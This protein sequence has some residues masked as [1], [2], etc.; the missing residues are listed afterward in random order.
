MTVF[1]FLLVKTLR[2]LPW[3]SFR[4][5]LL[6]FIFLYF[7]STLNF[8][9]M[10]WLSNPMPSNYYWLQFLQILLQLPSFNLSFLSLLL[11]TSY[12]WFDFLKHSAFYFQLLIKKQ[13]S[14]LDIPPTSLSF[15]WP[16][17]LYLQLKLPSYDLNFLSLILTIIILLPIPPNFLNMTTFLSFLLTTPYYPSLISFTA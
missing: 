5:S 4:L 3:Y 10:I 2:F 15:F 9:H 6:L 1:Q 13:K 7:I 11:K 16:F 8:L 12:I 17:I 14:Y